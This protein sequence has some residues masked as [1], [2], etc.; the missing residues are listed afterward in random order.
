MK[1]NISYYLVRG[2]YG[3]YCIIPK[4]MWEKVTKGLEHLYEECVVTITNP[5]EEIINYN[6]LFN[7]IF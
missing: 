3:K 4:R 7:V 5:Q 1:D 2:E 6:D